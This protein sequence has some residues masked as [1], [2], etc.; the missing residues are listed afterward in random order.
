M[1]TAYKSKLETVEA[2]AAELLRRQLRWRH[3]Q[4]FQW[5]SRK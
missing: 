4:C 3:A 2:D 1:Q 5:C